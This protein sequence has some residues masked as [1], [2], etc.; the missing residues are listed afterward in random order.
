[1]HQ[2]TRYRPGGTGSSEIPRMMT[3]P[4]T[5]RMRIMPKNSGPKVEL[6]CL[7]LGGKIKA[8]LPETLHVDVS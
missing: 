4:G 2:N 5:L 8:T 6:T 1:M 3:E 7:P